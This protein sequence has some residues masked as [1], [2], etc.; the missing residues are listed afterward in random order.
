MR[1]RIARTLLAAA[2]AGAVAT[3]LGFTGAGAAGAATMAVASAKTPTI[4]DPPSGGAPI[5][6]PACS[7]FQLVFD[8]GSCAGYEASGRDFRFAQAVITVPT[9]PTSTLAA[10]PIRFIGLSSPDSVA[11]AGIISCAVALHVFDYGCPGGVN[12]AA[13]GATAHASYFFGTNFIPIPAVDGGDGVFFSIYDNVR[14]NELHFV[15][16]LAGG[17][18]I[19]FALAAEGAVYKK[20][21]AL[22]DWSGSTP[23]MPVPPSGTTRVGQ[24]FEG[25]FTTVSGAQGTFWGPWT[26]RPAE[27]TSNGLAPPHGTLISAPGS[28]WS[29]GNSFM[30]MPGDAFGVWLYH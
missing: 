8:N 12:Y 1:R 26:L 25:R 18:S 21:V 11:G 7:S 15:I 3:T 2:A 24:F 27:A 28:L 14:G 23:D 19:A 29:D 6:S 30:N 5:Y 10:E 20:A 17:A 13:F 16:T 9:A 4:S 22:A